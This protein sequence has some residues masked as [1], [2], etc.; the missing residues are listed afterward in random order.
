M[1]HPKPCDR[2]VIRTLVDSDHT[3]SDILTQA[4]LN[5]A[6]GALPYG[7][8]VKQ[9][10][11][12][13]LRIER[14]APPTISAIRV[15]DSEQIDLLDRIQHE[16][17]QVVF[18]QPLTQAGRQQQLLLTIARNEVLG[19]RQSP[20]PQGPANRLKP[21]GRQPHPHPS[22]CDSLSYGNSVRCCHGGLGLGVARVASL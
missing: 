10:R 5:S 22:L 9:K 7:I 14:S 17:R 19:H 2:R 6:R 18:R 8:G 15:I 13:H 16:P 1:A 11:D 20:P 21:S 12:H 3:E 4:P